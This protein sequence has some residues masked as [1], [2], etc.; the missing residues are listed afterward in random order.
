MDFEHQDVQAFIDGHATPE[1]RARVRQA[2]A[3]SPELTEAIAR[4]L[5]SEQM[6]RHYFG[7]INDRQAPSRP[8]GKV[9][10]E[11]VRRAPRLNRLGIA[12]AI[13]ATVLV[14]AS[15]GWV[16]RD[17]WPSDPL[18]SGDV[19]EA[20]SSFVDEALIW[21]AD[22]PDQASV[23]QPVSSGVTIDLSHLGYYLASQ[24][25]VENGQGMEA[26]IAVYRPRQDNGAAELRQLLSIVWR[27]PFSGVAEELR[28]G[29]RG[30]RDIAFWQSDNFAAVVIGAEVDRFEDVARE[31]RR[32]FTSQ[33]FRAPAPEVL[34]VIE[35]APDPQIQQENGSEPPQG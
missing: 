9:L 32:V 27:A 1:Q 15:A 21:A 7:T 24:S 11:E 6:L 17:N 12:A 31:V 28:F 2:M 33:H 34:P 23:S 8:R 14:S 35:T 25:Q 5:R 22:T 30:N 16:A 18:G 19:T 4:A 20:L 10:A 3:A 13:A 29:D 26:T